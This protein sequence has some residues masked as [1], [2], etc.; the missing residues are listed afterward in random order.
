[1]R[2]KY[3][4]IFLDSG[5]VNPVTEQTQYKLSRGYMCCNFEGIWYLGRGGKS[6]FY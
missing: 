1:M 3:T 6:W 5:S 2:Q 4:T